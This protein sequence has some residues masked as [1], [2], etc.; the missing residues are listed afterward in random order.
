MCLIGRIRGP[1]T[2]TRTFRV[3]TT[4]VRPSLPLY[5]PE[6]FFC[7]T[8][9]QDKLTL[10]L[11]LLSEAPFQIHSSLP[12]QLAAGALRSAHARRLR[13]TLSAH[14]RRSPTPDPHSAEQSSLQFHRRRAACCTR[15]L[16][17]GSAC[18]LSSASGRWCGYAVLRR[19]PWACGVVCAGSYPSS[20]VCDVWRLFAAPW[21]VCV[22]RGCAD[23][24]GCL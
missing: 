21:P 11:P 2:A 23:P 4:R 9:L 14:A 22:T 7:R 19:G 16:R 24:C 15:A 18:H 8:A 5:E 13:L 17:H 12:R 6:L 1:P 3:N 10:A 20:S